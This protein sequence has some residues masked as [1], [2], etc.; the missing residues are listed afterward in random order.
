M[1]TGRDKVIRAWFLLLRR[2]SHTLNRRCS[3][4][5]HFE[6]V[7]VE[8]VEVRNQISD[9]LLLGLVVLPLLLLL[10]LLPLLEARL[11]SLERERRRRLLTGLAFT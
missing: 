3:F 5:N 7:L 6:L 4:S 10:L 8:L 9:A 11:A 1:R 2:E